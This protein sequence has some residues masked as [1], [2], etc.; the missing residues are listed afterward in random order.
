VT[1]G[2]SVTLAASNIT[3]GNPDA[4]VTQV[5]FYYI[6]SNGNQDLLGD[7]T[8]SGGIWSYSFTVN[9]A[10]GSYTGVGAG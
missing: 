10:S 6:D 4:S 5:A 2:S 8:Q 3:D 7:G 9:L 1:T